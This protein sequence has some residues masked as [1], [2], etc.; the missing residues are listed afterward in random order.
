MERY[1]REEPRGKRKEPPQEEEWAKLA[2]PLP[3]TP[4]S[5]QSPS[6]PMLFTVTTLKTEPPSDSD[7]P[8][9]N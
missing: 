8:K 3:P 4:P 5:P 2:V 6:P 1:L 7:E 9:G